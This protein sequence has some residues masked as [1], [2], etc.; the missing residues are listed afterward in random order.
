MN[1]FIL[2]LLYTLG[3][4]AVLAYP[5]K[6]ESGPSEQPR[7]S[8]DSKPSEEPNGQK[9]EPCSKGCTCSQDDYSLELNV[10]C[11]TRNFT[12]VPS[13]IPL[14]TRSLWL[15]GNLFTNLPAAAFEKLSNLEFLNL[16]SGLLVSLDG[17]VFRGLNSLAHLHLERNN[18]RSLPGIVFQGTPN[19]ASLSLNNNQLSRIDDKL[20]AGL[21]QMWLLNLGWNS[22]SVLPE[23]GFQDL[24]GLRE[25]VLAGNLTVAPRAFVGMKSLRWLDLS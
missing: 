8:E 18:I 23:T 5:N 16:Q 7:F 2:L 21:S 12:Q 1:H 14:S 22:L 17:H 4:S 6:E 10:Y 15:D 11:S 9:S 24:H 13:D 3:T 25:L 19:L 20:F